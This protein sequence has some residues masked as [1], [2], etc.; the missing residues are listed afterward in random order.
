VKY[1]T[2]IMRWLG[3]MGYTHCF[4]VAGGNSMHLLDGART[5]MTCIPVVHEVA[6]GIA[7]EYFNEVKAA[8]GRRDRA[9]ALVTAGPG[10]TNILSAMTGA[11]LESRE[12][13][14]IGGQVKSTDLASA[15]LRQRGIQEVDGIS[16]ATPV[17]VATSRITT[18]VSKSAFQ[19]V[20]SAGGTGR[21]GPVLL[22]VCLDAQGAPVD[23]AE[24]ERGTQAVPRHLPDPEDGELTQLVD[25]LRH[26]ERPVILLGGGTDRSAV[27]RALVGL[28]PSRIP[29]M[30]TWNGADRIGSDD[31]NY[32]GR[33]DTW[34][35]RSANALIQQSDAVIALGARLGLQQTGFNWQ[36]FA[37]LAT[38]VQV[39]IDP[40]ELRKGH[41]RVDLAVRADA[42]VVLER[43]AESKLPTWDDWADF[44]QRVRALLPP[45]EAV[46]QTAD[47]YLDPYQF[48]SDLSELCEPEDVIV[49]CSSGG[50]FTVAMQVF[51]Q[52]HGQIIITDK[53]LASMGYGL[54]GAIGAAVAGGRRTILLEGD[55]GFSQNMQELATVAVNRLPVKVF[56]FSNEGYASIRMT[57]RNY[58]D[59][60]YLGCDTAT[61][62]GFPD[63]PLLFQAFRIPL[64]DMRDAKLDSEGF[65]DAFN[66]AGPTAFLVPV[67]PEQTY[68]PKITSRVTE[69]GTMQSNPLHLMS[70]ALPEALAAEVLPYLADTT[71]EPLT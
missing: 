69:S 27:N 8:S 67:D 71:R 21:R 5:S 57:Q 26:A 46:N 37:P 29:I 9:F 23:L 13:L 39:D 4:F 32:A 2:V 50:S 17:S 55:G 56:L 70:P 63:W 52:K 38:I 12:L 7:V 36:E 65:F 58:F 28:K 6:A 64:V 15:G 35:Q 68:Y 40:A 47:G 25:V 22:E 66:A 18:P 45:V 24:L 49:P 19:A 51:L 14:V 20:V 1:S 54:S 48:V 30:T 10:L 53:G 61:G 41:P 42:N 31:P 16:L 3:E 62:L 11:F 33:P 34:G 44:C 60:G 59:G 43:I